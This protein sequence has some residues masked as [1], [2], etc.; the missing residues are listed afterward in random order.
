MSD[1]R[2]NENNKTGVRLYGLLDEGHKAIVDAFMLFLYNQQRENTNKRKKMK[3]NNI[4][5]VDFTTESIDKWIE[6]NGQIGVLSGEV[7]IEA[8]RELT[9]NDV[10]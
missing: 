6:I 1:V 9:K 3:S 7:G 10:W 8:M 4:K 5:R 2:I